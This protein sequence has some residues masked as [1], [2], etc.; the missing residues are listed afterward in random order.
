MLQEGASCSARS[1]PA[2]STVPSSSPSNPQCP[3][4]I[5]IGTFTDCSTASMDSLKPVLRLVVDDHL[6]ALGVARECRLRSSSADP[7]RALG[8]QADHPVLVRCAVPGVP[9][10]SM[11]GTCR[12]RRSGRAR[13]QY[14]AQSAREVP[15]PR[16]RPP[17]G[18]LVAD[19]NG[20]CSSS[21]TLFPITQAG[22]GSIC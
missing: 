13:D 1:R 4:I 3:R 9:W 12:A 19:R 14:D 6:A 7:A 18:A 8:R 20:R 17:P 2:T 11:P 16:W 21:R 15:D 10:R 5:S 22:G